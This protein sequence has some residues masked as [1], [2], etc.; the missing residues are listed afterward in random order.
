MRV[1][2]ALEQWPICRLPRF[3]RRCHDRGL[4]KA[5]ITRSGLPRFTSFERL[6]RARPMNDLSVNGRRSLQSFEI[7]NFFAVVFRRSAAHETI[8]PPDETIS[9]FGADVRKHRI[10]IDRSNKTADRAGI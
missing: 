7:I 3:Q 8:L 10:V 2:G 4:T 5:R 9:R 6:A 1:A